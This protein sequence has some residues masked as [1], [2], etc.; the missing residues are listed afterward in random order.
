MPQATDHTNEIIDQALSGL[1]SRYE[2]LAFKALLVSYFSIR[3]KNYIIRSVFTFVMIGFFA[4]LIWMGPLALALTTLAVQVKCFQEI[5]AVGYAVYRVHGLPWFRSISWFFL[6]A[7][8]YFIYGEGLAEYFGV[9]L[10]RAVS[11]FVCE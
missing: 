3:W 9:L 7:S 2:I 8:N 5:I 11:C 1:P 4:W 6:V 10:N